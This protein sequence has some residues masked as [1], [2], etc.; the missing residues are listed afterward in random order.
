MSSL[1][2]SSA[3]DTSKVIEVSLLVET[4]GPS[5]A[6]PVA[7]A[8]DRGATS[9]Q[10]LA[11]LTGILGQAAADGPL[12][13]RRSGIRLDSGTPIGD[14]ELRDGDILSA[15]P[16]TGAPRHPPGSRGSWQLIAESGPAAGIVYD[17]ELSSRPVTIGR[18]DQAMLVVPDPSVSAVHAVL[19]VREDG[20]W[21]ADLGSTNGTAVEG[22][23]IGKE[24]VPLAAGAVARIGG[25]LLSV[26]RPPASSLLT[27][28]Y[29]DGRLLVNR[30]PRA[31]PSSEP[32]VI[33]L[34]APP[35]PPT[36][37]RLPIM[38]AL[39]PLALGVVIAEVA[40]NAMFLMFAVLSPVMAVISV[41]SDRRS[42]K[43]AHKKALARFAQQVERASASADEA[44][45]VDLRVQR[46]AAPGVGDL[47]SR[48][49]HL[50]Q[51]LW[52]RRP[53]DHDF[54]RL[55]V[56]MADRPARLRFDGVQP[57]D[58]DRPPGPLDSIQDD[59]K[60]DPSVPVTVP[61]SD[62]VLGISGPQDDSD[63]LAR[64][65]ICAAACLH[66]PRDLAIVALVHPQREAAWQFLA[67]MPHTSVLLPQA[68]SVS[69]SIEDHRYLLSLVDEILHQRQ[70]RAGGALGSAK[71]KQMPHIL[72]V[73][74]GD[75]DLSRPVLSRVLE[76]GPAA[77]ITAVVV[78]EAV[79]S[80]P[81]ECTHVVTLSSTPEAAGELSLVQVREGVAVDGIVGDLGLLR[82]I[83]NVALALA[84]LRDV[85]AG[86]SSGELPRQVNLLELLDLA[87][88]TPEMIARRW[89]RSRAG[90]P[91]V[92]GVN[93]EGPEVLDL[94]REGPHML[95]GG[96]TGAGK[97][98]L[99]QTFVASLA[100]SHPPSRLTFVLIDYKGGAAFK[101]C[102]D[103]PHVTGYFTD[104][105]GHL[106]RRALESLEAEVRRREHLLAGAGYKNLIDFEHGDPEH[107]P[108]SLLLVFD[109]FAF[110]KTSVPEFVD[111][112]VDIAAR[113]RS[114][115][116]HLV[117][118][119]QRPAGII[120]EKIRT[121]VPVRISL[122]FH[123]DQE[124]VDI[125]TV[126]DAARIPDDLVGRAFVRS[127]SDI[128]PVQVAYVGGHR[129]GARDEPVVNARPISFGPA[130]TI[131]PRPDTD[132][133]GA[134]D[135]QR[136]VTAVC[137]AWSASGSSRPQRPWLDPLK[138]SYALESLA[139]GTEPSEHLAT[140]AGVVDEPARQSQDPLVLDLDELGHLLVFGTGLSGKTTLL[141]T[142]AAG[143]AKRWTASD[144]YL[145]CLDFATRGL[146]ALDA[147]P[148]CGGVATAND[149][150]RAERILGLLERMVAERQVAL[151]NAGA[152]SFIELRSEQPVGKRSPWVV[153]L[154][155]GYSG[156]MD[157][158]G[159][160]D[161]GVQIDR[162][163]QIAADGSSVGVHL[164]ISVDRRGGVPNRLLAA[165]PG[166]V[167]LRMGDADEYQWLGLRNVGDADLPPGRGFL[168][169]GV[170]IQ[171]AV[172]GDDASGRAQVE[173][174]RGLGTAL[175][176]AS[177]ERAPRVDVLGDDIPAGALVPVVAGARHIPF[178]IDGSDL[179]TLEVHL[180]EGPTFLI[181]GPDGSGRSVALATL[182]RGLRASLPEASIVL[183]APRMTPLATLDVWTS[184]ARGL[185]EI[186]T[187]VQD[188]VVSPAASM[189]DPL[190]V[191]IDDA[192]ELLE[193]SVADHLEKLVRR[194]R[195][196]TTIVCAACQTH[197]AHRAYAGWLSEMRKAKHGLVIM[198]DVD[199]DGDLFGVRF[200]RRS[201]VRFPP[202]RGYL[203]QRSGVSLVQVAR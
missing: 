40:H 38:T 92:I 166:R 77:G 109:E 85:T 36:K 22:A 153:L 125:L 46:S 82:V 4:D 2:T 102:V 177:P 27:P 12:Y 115:G 60:I 190:V 24:P 87:E 18:G 63:A 30:P 132:D 19:Q 136:L 148:Q 103:L 175:S 72:L 76:S 119:T 118:A 130:P 161:G 140:V 13:L 43:S 137:G 145:Y 95:V 200:P 75:I 117:L 68:A 104:L 167:I 31:T 197:R 107:A 98:E 93:G 122:R 189:T 128:H 174:V 198:P 71:R 94:Q 45:L 20:V 3:S 39:I 15:T 110:L 100:A 84:P 52:E 106:A 5:S 187:F 158:F 37:A 55:R 178:A 202:G 141:R 65:L 7:V 194:A 179:G 8:Y 193:G 49:I 139:G 168:A 80:L 17:L 34:P 157:V 11:S 48:A 66:S 120:D 131:W 160:L 142:I 133:S 155:D 26:R 97:S 203:A 186:C 56:G 111:G 164:V 191:I 53:T 35:K 9:G 99:L 169:S 81:G 171:V 74:A 6:V 116:V 69:T 41:V 170:E 78:S 154:L 61:L 88:P 124:S 172:L 14:L 180:D 105:D 144:L 188:L 44:H 58:P 51:S 143:L 162:L 83:E 1:S 21:I 32:P 89:T 134:S 16:A 152:G 176:A 25:S 173:A 151:G 33:A 123:D 79:R 54:L 192:E 184:V 86:G 201:T 59:H 163:A 146:Q 50:E 149:I 29:R 126:P 121:N 129:S 112:V 70:E 138:A 67:W 10:L 135:L 185:D 159:D 108:P 42:G 96:T 199:V 165:I 57:P 113:G 127:G 196:G 114:L 195:D 91:G 23:A 147:L 64:S 90:L 47:A 181:C 73:V 183:L 62:S 156:F 182:A 101:Q 28:T 150:E